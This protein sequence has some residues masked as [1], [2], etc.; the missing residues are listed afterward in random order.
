MGLLAIALA[1]LVLELLVAVLELLVAVPF[2]LVPVPFLLVAVLLL[3]APSKRVNTGPM[4]VADLRLWFTPNWAG[5]VPLY[6]M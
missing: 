6:L 1:R 3:L 2:L 5:E 4:L